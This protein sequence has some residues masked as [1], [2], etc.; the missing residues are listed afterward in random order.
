[1]TGV[2]LDDKNTDARRCGG[3]AS[4]TWCRRA[5]R[6]RRKRQGESESHAAF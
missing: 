3:A 2:R 1:M 5:N 4:G 6:V